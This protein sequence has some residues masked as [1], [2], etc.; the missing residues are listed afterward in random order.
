MLFNALDNFSAILWRDQ[1]NFQ[2]NDDEVHFV[3]DQHPLLDFYN[4]SSLKQQSAVRHVAPLGHIILN[5]VCLAKKQQ[6]QLYSLWFD[7]IGAR[8]HGLPHSRRER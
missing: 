7:P 4:D 8:T 6:I 3:L 5:D 2:R 1:V